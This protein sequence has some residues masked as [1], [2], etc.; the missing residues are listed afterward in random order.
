MQLADLFNLSFMTCV[1][2]SVFK[3]ANVVSVCFFLTVTWLPQG[4][5]YAT[6][7]GQPQSPNV[8]RCVF[9]YSTRMSPGVL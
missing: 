6:V 4:E 5:L 8:N 9:T 1:F 7:D 2:P 3:A